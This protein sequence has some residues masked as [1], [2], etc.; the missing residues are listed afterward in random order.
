MGRTEQR[1]TKTEDR[2]RENTQSRQQRK[3]WEKNKRASQLWN[4]NKKSNISVTGVP[5]EKE[6]RAEN[7]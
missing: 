7:S 3:C 6:D 4:D 1:T 5:E 2:A